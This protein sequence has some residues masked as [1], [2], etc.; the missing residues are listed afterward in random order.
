VSMAV[1]RM[2]VTA[3]HYGEPQLIMADMTVSVKNGTIKHGQ[4]LSPVSNLMSL[5]HFISLAPRETV[6]EELLCVRLK[7]EADSR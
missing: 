6:N 3:F 1:P 7:Y 2:A 5:F 4:T